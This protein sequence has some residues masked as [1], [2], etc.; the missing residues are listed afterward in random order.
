MYILFI[1]MISGYGFGAL[2]ALLGLGGRAGRAL[3]SIGTVVGAAAGLAL[4]MATF[5]TGSPFSV[6]IPSLL[7]IAGGMAVRL[8]GLCAFFL[9]LSGLGASSAG[10]DGAC[11]AATYEHWR[12]A[13]PL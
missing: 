8:D 1:V 10:V 7:P 9:T 5:R 12:C 11:R 13:A 6:S 2:T 4:V 3:T